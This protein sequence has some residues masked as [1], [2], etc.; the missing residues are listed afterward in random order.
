MRNAEC[1]MLNAEFVAGRW[2][3]CGPGI[4]HSSFR[5]HLLPLPRVGEERAVS[6]DHVLEEGGASF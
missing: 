4:H 6:R 5:F 3:D 1:G 2:S